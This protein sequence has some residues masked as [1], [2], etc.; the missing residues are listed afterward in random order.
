[1]PL[2]TKQ[3]PGPS[4]NGPA[5]SP[6][7]R[8]V[9]VTDHADDRFLGVVYGQNG[10]GKTSLACTFP[11]PIL[12]VGFEDGTKSVDTIE[13][14]DLLLVRST[15]WIGETLDRVA[16]GE[17]SH[18]ASSKNGWTK[19]ES[20]T[21]A[22]YATVV[23]DTATSLQDLC[24]KEIL[25]L[26]DLPV[27]LE[28]GVASM[29]QYRDRSSKTREFL[30]KFFDLP[31]PITVVIL[32]QEK[33]HSKGGADDEGDARRDSEMLRPWWGPNLGKATA[34]WLVQKADHVCQTY[35]RELIVKKVVKGIGGKKDRTV[36][37]RTG[38]VEFCLRAEKSHPGHAAKMR[39]GREIE[40]PGVIV[41]PDYQKIM[42]A[43]RGEK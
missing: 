13:G 31:S 14:V 36:E 27:M 15:E 4:R 19:K 6:L 1:M 26:E 41:N 7:D 25:G 37:K 38:K 39:T 30:R 29:D 8:I 5:E 17:P 3:K 24:L 22:P 12:L 9:P 16:E 42:K 11:R 2:V 23:A 40:M 21:G 10:T 33:D 28:W 43:I 34:E 20:R 32:A 35:T 18:W